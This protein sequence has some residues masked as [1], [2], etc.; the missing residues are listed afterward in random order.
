MA[1]RVG[2]TN[3]HS[4]RRHSKRRASIPSPPSSMFA[5]SAPSSPRDSCITIP[6]GTAQLEP[7]EPRAGRDSAL[8]T[9]GDATARDGQQLAAVGLDVREQRDQLGQERAMHK[10]VEQPQARAV[11]GRA[12]RS[13]PAPQQKTSSQVGQLPQPRDRRRG[14]VLDSRTGRRRPLL[15]SVIATRAVTRRRSA[16]RVTHRLH[17]KC[18]CVCVCVDFPNG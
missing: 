18:V 7:C 10:Q 12:G 13:C 3:H 1:S 4:K 11:R 2:M 9:A 17:F 5:S 8:P 15:A 6:T 14:V 16:R